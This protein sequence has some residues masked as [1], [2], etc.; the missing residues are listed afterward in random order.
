[1]L[2][3]TLPSSENHKW[4][5]RNHT[6][7][8]S[9]LHL[10]AFHGAAEI[11]SPAGPLLFKHGLSAGFHT[12]L[13]ESSACAVPYLFGK[14]HMAFLPAVPAL[15]PGGVERKA[16]GAVWLG[17]SRTSLLQRVPGRYGHLDVPAALPMPPAG[18]DISLGTCQGCS[19]RSIVAMPFLTHTT[20]VPLSLLPAE[21]FWCMSPSSCCLQRC[22]LTL[23]QQEEAE[24]QRVQQ[25]VRSAKPPRLRGDPAGVLGWFC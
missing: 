14:R 17:P 4:R 20:S 9:H 22:V 18:W 7:S 11:R 5:R 19:V 2:L 25:F 13:S 16:A 3:K 23:F 10:T 8:F 6:A 21:V 24:R 15:S 1:M 12:S